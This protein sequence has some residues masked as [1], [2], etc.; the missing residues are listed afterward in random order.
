M[1]PNEAHLRAALRSG[2]GERIDADAVIGRAHRL[3][4]GRRVRVASAAAAVVAVAGI[5]TGA[6]LLNRGS[7][8]HSGTPAAQAGNTTAR[9]VA[10]GHTVPQAAP[11]AP[12]SSTLSAGPT[13][14][15]AG[16]PA[17]PIRLMAP[18]GGGTGQFGGSGPLFTGPVKQLLICGYAA[19]QLG[20]PVEFTGSYL[21]EQNGGAQQ[22]ADSLNA[23]ATTAPQLR[24]PAQTLRELVLYATGTSGDRLA[25]VTVNFGVCPT[26]ATNGTAVRF[27][28][29]PP[30]QWAT[31][32]QAMMNPVPALHV[33]APM[34]PS[35]SPLH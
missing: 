6:A 5:G 22:L 2:E 28:W 30:G 11:T 16:C 13:P 10:T 17:E 24:C 23:A 3:R 4:H 27:A 31:Q 19:A 12:I 8:G 35:G 26:L 7:A 1:S 33:T 32:L 18:G 20:S 9:H 14:S 21:L 29:T 25:P 34:H 15:H